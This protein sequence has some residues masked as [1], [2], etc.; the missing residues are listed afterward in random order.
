MADLV[1]GKADAFIR[2]RLA[3]DR[4]RSARPR[5]DEMIY[6]KTPEKITSASAGYVA[7]FRQGR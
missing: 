1:Y 3:A 6:A 4:H 2:E 5:R 7:A